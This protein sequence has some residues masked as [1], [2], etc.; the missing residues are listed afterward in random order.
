LS[1]II[2]WN[3]R[4]LNKKARRDAVRQTIVSTRPDLVCLQETKKAST[5]LW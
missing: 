3:V 5:V 2:I 4:G 1:K